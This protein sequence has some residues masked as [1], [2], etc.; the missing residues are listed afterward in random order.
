MKRKILLVE[1]SLGDIALTRRAFLKYPVEFETVDNGEKAIERL[2]DRTKEPP[3]MI[4]LDLNL[5]RVSGWEVLE[6]IKQVPHIKRI[7]VVILT[8]SEAETDIAR[9]YDLHASAYMQKPA[10]PDAFRELAEDFEAFWFGRAK[11]P[12]LRGM[13]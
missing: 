9:S 8:S 5:P 4:L 13:M 10:T 7:P 11:I 3:E 1:D 12:Q 6:R 2:M